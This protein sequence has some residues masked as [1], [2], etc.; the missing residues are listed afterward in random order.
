MKIKAKWGSSWEVEIS[1]N[2][3]F[4]FLEKSGWDKFVRDNGLGSSEFVTF[5]HKRKMSF[6]LNI[7]KQDGKEILQA[8]QSMAF[9]A[10]SS[11]ILLFLNY[12]TVNKIKV[13]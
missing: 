9:L 8:P 3:R 2:P 6:A 10:S 4:Y 7:F 11:K 5:T 12:Q 13:H 1:K